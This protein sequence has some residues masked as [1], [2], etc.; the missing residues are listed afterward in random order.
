MDLQEDRDDHEDMYEITCP[1]TGSTEHLDHS[2]V[3]SSHRVM[4]G[5]VVYLRCNCGDVA[6]WVTPPT[7]AHHPARTLVA[8]AA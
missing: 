2:H 3:I 5:H 8:A 4:R 7:P 6:M 1:T